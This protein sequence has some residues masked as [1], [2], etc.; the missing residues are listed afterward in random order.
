MIRNELKESIRPTLLD[1]GYS[2][3]LRKQ[4]RCHEEWA[5]SGTGENVFV[6]SKASAATDLI[7]HTM[8]RLSIFNRSRSIGDT[9]S[10]F[11]G[12]LLFRFSRLRIL[13]LTPANGDVILSIV[14]SG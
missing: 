2:V 10:V 4:L 3:E 9:Q 14:G 11:V 7:R 13:F 12:T 5:E 6:V 8:P 1:L